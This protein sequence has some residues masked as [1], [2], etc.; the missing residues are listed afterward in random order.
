MKILPHHSWALM[1]KQAVDLQRRL[2]AELQP[3]G[4]TVPVQRVAGVDVS[5]DAQ[6]DRLW[7]G[8]VIL[9]YA[10]LQ[11]LEQVVVDGP[12]E[13][14]YVPGLLSFREVPVILEA[15]RQI[16]MPPDLII[17]DGQGLAHP[18]RFGLA[19]HLGSLLKIPALGCAKSRLIGTYAEPAPDKGCWSPLEDN[20]QIIGSVLRTR[21]NVSPVFISAGYRTGLEQARDIVLHCCPKYRLPETTRL[22]HKA[23]NKQRMAARKSA[24]LN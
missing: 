3:E 2:A 17:C 10:T 4:P 1:P 16:E 22:A 11:P 23:V 14:P 9:D 12:S 6:L 7:G 20:G 13:F 19:C 24:E 18:R 8:V 5:Y 21:T 15:M